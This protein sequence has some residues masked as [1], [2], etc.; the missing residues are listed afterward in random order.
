MKIGKK[1]AI[2]G[3]GFCGLAAAW[4]LLNKKNIKVDLFDRAGLSAGA[5]SLSAGLLHP[6]GGLHSKLNWRG[7]DGM[8]ATQELLEV[9]SGASNRPIAEVTG[10]L[11]AAVTEENHRDYALCAQKYEDV[12][13]LSAKECQKLVPGL[14]PLPGIF[15]KTALTINAKLYLKGL[16]AACQ[17]KGAAFFQ[18]S[19]NSLKELDDYDGIVIAG[20]PASVQ[21][22]ETNGLALTPVKGQMLE[23]E[24][25]S[26]LPPLRI[27]LNSQIYIVMNPHFGSCFVGATF[28][29]HFSTSEPEAD[30]AI[31]LL[32]PRAVQ[33]LPDLAHSKVIDCKSGV[34]ASGLNHKPVLKQMSDKC[35]IFSGMGSKGLLYHALYAKELA[36]HF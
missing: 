4:H 27:P 10:Q 21:Y 31:K 28:E 13:W 18:R 7:K 22:E 25:P 32:L 35:W 1:I 23:I 30:S 2:I 15:I 24:W 33:L 16:W 20:G 19:I 8:E 5:S 14:A 34:R 17:N 29:R 36:I 12:E 26:H 9:A 6:Y 11:R 3:S